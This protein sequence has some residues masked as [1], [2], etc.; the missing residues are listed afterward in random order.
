MRQVFELGVAQI[1][2]ARAFSA[3]LPIQWAHWLHPIEAVDSVH[4]I[5]AMTS[6]YSK[7]FN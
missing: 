5:T 3:P 4:R 1:K 2:A 7:Y 6:G